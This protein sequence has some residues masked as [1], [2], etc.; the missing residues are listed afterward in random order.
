MA[1]GRMGF[2]YIAI[3]FS[4]FTQL[5]VGQLLLLFQSVNSSLIFKILFSFLISPN[6]KKISILLLSF[7][8]FVWVFITVQC[9]SYTVFCN[10]LTIISPTVYSRYN[11]IQRAISEDVL[12]VSIQIV[13]FSLC[14]SLVRICSPPILFLCHHEQRCV[15][16]SNLR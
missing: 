13:F 12:E 3:S 11:N 6:T 2:P 15:I 5:V 1:V 7:R 10:F 8:V 14:Y 16:L 4:P 9:N